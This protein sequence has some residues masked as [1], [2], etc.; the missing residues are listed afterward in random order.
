MTFE[1]PIKDYNLMIENNINNLSSIGQ[2]IE[3]WNLYVINEHNINNN[4]IFQEIIN[5]TNI[6]NLIEYNHLSDIINNNNESANNNINDFNFI[7]NNSD[8]NVNDKDKNSDSN[9]NKT[10]TSHPLESKSQ[11]SFDN[12]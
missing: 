3:S 7:Y 8:N 6:N 10:Q 12:Y 9:E 1:I 11:Y 2:S 5:L 4:S